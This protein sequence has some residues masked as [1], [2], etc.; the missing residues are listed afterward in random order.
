M[1]LSIA[2]ADTAGSPNATTRQRVTLLPKV[3][4]F[5]CQLCKRWCHTSDSFNQRLFSRESLFSREKA[6]GPDLLITH[7]NVILEKL[8]CR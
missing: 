3:L 1:T 8:P 4:S 6:S 2:E 7:A 5:D